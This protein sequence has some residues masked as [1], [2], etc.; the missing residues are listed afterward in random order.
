[1]TDGRRPT[2][3]R[4]SVTVGVLAGAALGTVTNVFTNTFPADWKW[5]GDV[6]LMGAIFV[7]CLVLS[8]TVAVRH[9][10]R[11]P[12]TPGGAR[13]ILDRLTSR[14]A[15]DYRRWVSES[16]RNLDAKGLNIIGPFIP[17]LD[18]SFVRLALTSSAPGQVGSGMVPATRE[19][20]HDR[21]IW[22]FLNRRRRV[23]L[24]VLGAPGSGK[25]TLLSHV[26][27]RTV[28]ANR[29]MTRPIP[30]WLQ[31]RDQAKAI[32]A[33]PNVSLLSLIRGSIP[34]SVGPE[35]A[36]WWEK[37]LRAGRCVILLDGLDEAGEAGTRRDVAQWINRQ[38]AAHPGN[39]F[40]ITSRPPGYRNAFVDATETVQVLPFGRPQVRAF[41][42]KWYT[43]AERH[44]AD[45]G[46]YAA[47]AA[48]GREA[49][50]HLLRQ[51]DAI[52]GLT[53][54]TA[55]PLLLTMIANVHRYGKQLPEN[56]A[57]LYREVCETMLGRRDEARGQIVALALRQRLMLLGR[58]A[59]AWMRQGIRGQDRRTLVRTV[60][61]WLDETAPG[62]TAE[63]FLEDMEATGLLPVPDLEN[64]AFTH[65]TFQ[66]Y[67]A[68]A[69][70]AESG[71]HHL[72]TEVVDD[73][74]WRETILLYGAGE[75]PNPIVAS[76]VRSGTLVA[77]SLAFELAESDDRV[78]QGLRDD[79]DRL[80]HRGLRPDADPADRAL[81][82]DVLI[83]RMLRAM[84]TTPDGTR[85]SRRPITTELYE[86]FCSETGTPF[87]EGTEPA[88]P[89]APARGIWQRDAKAFLAWINALV[90][91][92]PRSGKGIVFRLPTGAEVA[93][94]HPALPVWVVEGRWR[95][96]YPDK[97]AAVVTADALLD[98][99]SADLAGSHLLDKG[100]EDLA[101]RQTDMVHRSMTEMNHV[102]AQM[103]EL[104]RESTRHILST[105]ADTAP[106][107]RT[108]GMVEDLRNRAER[109]HA[110]IGRLE[111]VL[112]GIADRRRASAG[113]G[114]LV[115][116]LGRVQRALKSAEPG[117]TPR[118]MGLFPIIRAEFE[119]I[120]TSVSRIRSIARGAP[121]AVERQSP[122][123][124]VLGPISYRNLALPVS[125]VPGD[126]MRIVAESLLP[127]R[128]LR[129]NRFP[130]D[131]GGLVARLA[132]MPDRP[133][134][135][136]DPSFFEAALDRLLRVAHPI[137][138]RE[139]LITPA[140]AAA[141]RAPALVLARFAQ[142]ADDN[143]LTATLIEL[144]AATCLL[145]ERRVR[146]ELLETLI[147]AH[148]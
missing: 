123:D 100:L 143:R 138:A 62:I 88:D 41:L 99:L 148:D 30:V 93:T 19:N 66:E 3:S 146:P 142:K 126:P 95:V 134:S 97:K 106:G 121:P 139:R 25:T 130:V 17:E 50:A 26:A 96:R 21:T 6:K 45:N 63:R 71:L 90:A 53:D 49:A 36:R 85:I 12:D 28:E 91:A 144:A 10:R 56:R 129:A 117:S 33:D 37:R 108:G 9:L 98:A 125:A 55:N 4:S 84:V 7:G 79:L 94:V 76:A 107:N 31:L 77:R 70:I 92:G 86:L 5:A 34:D 14:Y 102:A 83:G 72:L 81:A 116:D 101:A 141:I 18:A 39:D 69:Y 29:A 127:D 113:W 145:E 131:L 52:P 22:N 64:F 43:A 60:Q 11:D 147:L 74:W 73:P 140:T 59:F 8:I 119:E 137:V 89:D 13:A 115:V 20:G 65:Q 2:D 78:D 27:R 58:L 122:I 87:I 110:E 23:V 104:V 68:A 135:P 47:A 112:L 103:A 48:R 15:R 118:A 105:D 38:V 61:P 57:M 54:L 136:S 46:E 111:T 82:L 75:D 80:L 114:D 40:V 51:I 35:P 133:G 42:E 44:D 24:A 67:L 109:L 128:R 132:A 16:R 32:A 124:H 120:D 1:M